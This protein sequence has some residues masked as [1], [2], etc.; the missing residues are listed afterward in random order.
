MQTLDVKELLETYYLKFNRVDFIPDDPVSIPHRYSL[1]QDIEIMGFMA[2]ILAWGQRKTI[3]QKC[4]DLD[5]RFSGKPYEFITQ[6]SDQDF[7]ALLGFKHR[8]FNDTDLL[9][10]VEALRA[11]YQQYNSLEL[12]FLGKPGDAT[13]ESGLIAFRERFFSLPEVPSRTTKHVSSPA[14]NSACKRL[15]MYLRWMVRTDTHGV[16]FGLWKKIHSS[17]LVCP[18]DVHVERVARR[19]QLIQRKQTDWQTALELTSNLR[20]LD[21]LDPVKYDFALFGMGIEESGFS[22]KRKR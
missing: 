20:A 21:P 19:L 6:A 15:V 3:L 14:K 4:L 7:K 18:C 9:Y 5:N 17:Q 2:A 22:I 13:V 8:T 1:Q 16:D 11:L 12:A 10:F